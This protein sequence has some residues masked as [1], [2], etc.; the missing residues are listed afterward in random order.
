MEAS[1][2][3]AVTTT[4]E[5]QEALFNTYPC[6]ALLYYVQ[7]PSTTSHANSS[8]CR[9]ASDSISL[10]PFPAD[11]AF[12]VVPPPGIHRNP[13]F[14]LSRYSSSRGS[15]N[16]FLH[17]KKITYDLGHIDV[18]KHSKDRSRNRNRFRVVHELE[19][20]EEGGE[21]KRRSELWRFVALDPSA[22]CCC[23]AFQICWRFLVSLGL[24]L[25]VFFLATRPPSPTVTFQISRVK[26]FNLGEGLDMTGV[27][28]KILTCNSSVDVE[29]DNKSKL[30][31]LHVYPV[32]IHM[33]FGRL[34]FATSSQEGEELY[35][36]S[37]NLLRKRLYVGVKDM[38]MYGAGRDME[39]MLES[40]K[41]L[42]LI[43]KVSSRSTYHVVWN[44]IKSKYHH[45][46]ECL[47]V[48][49]AVYDAHNHTQLFNSTCSTT[50][51]HA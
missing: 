46:A 17:D 39:D 19:G 43:I 21:H 30:F 12:I 38:P 1:S 33:A 50:T 6:S 47:V 37:N 9:H 13:D 35:V 44:L 49:K 2:M 51:S 22:S 45:H 26:H 16:Y 40:G 18:Q 24:A 14:T 28:T 3:S 32:T 42:P 5:E 31:G 4:E 48:L 7:S 8:D 15:N 34:I 10:S 11:D 20:V 25:L 23:V 36:Q 27:V 29:I 41:G